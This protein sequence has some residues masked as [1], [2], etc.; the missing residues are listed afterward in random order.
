MEFL[1]NED[2]MDFKIG[3]FPY[4]KNHSAMGEYHYVVNEGYKGNWIDPVCN[5]TYSGPSWIITEENGKHFMEQMRIK[6]DKPHDTHPMLMSGNDNWFNYTI[7]AKLRMFNTSGIAGIGFCV[8][9]S[10][11]LL[12]LVFTEG[13]LRLEYR[14]KMKKK[15]LAKKS[16]NYNCDVFYE[17]KA[18]CNE[19][20][21]TCYIDNE[22]DFKVENDQVIQGGKVCITATDPVQFQS[23]KVTC[24][25]EVNH[26]INKKI[27]AKE[28]LKKQLYESM[29]KMKLYKK[30]DLKD[31]GSGR[32]LRFGH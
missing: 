9:N 31:F 5:H 22:I 1:L 19:N 7:H 3:E 28:R 32:Q 26:E 23:V 25:E 10:M 15:I 18:T 4:D 24:D 27:N 20:I 17:L 8:Q 29:P 14:H 21:V 16:Y 11:N 12:A 6:T 2:F 30:I 13:E